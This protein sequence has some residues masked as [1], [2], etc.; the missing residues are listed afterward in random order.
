MPAAERQL[1]AVGELEAVQQDLVLDVPGEPVVVAEQR[2]APPRVA[3]EPAAAEVEEAL[4]S[5]CR[6]RDLMRLNGKLLSLGTNAEPD[7]RAPRAVAEMAGAGV[8]G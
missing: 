6:T 1:R 3:C 7:S 2:A 5:L 8:T 4:E